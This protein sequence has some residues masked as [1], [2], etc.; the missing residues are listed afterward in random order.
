MERALVMPVLAAL[1]FAAACRGEAGTTEVDTRPSARFVNA[2]TGSGSGGFT[3][4]GQFAPGSALAP[5]QATQTCSNVD[6]GTTIFGFGPASS[7]GNALSGSPVVTSNDETI[8]AGGRYIVVAAGTAANP[9]LFVFGNGFS[10]ELT[11][12][13]AAVRFVSLVPA[14]GTGATNYVFYRGEIGAT[15]PLALNLPFGVQSG[16]S[17]VPSGAS[18]FSAMQVPGNVT[19]VPSSSA[20]LQGGSVNTIALVRDASGGFQLIHIPRCS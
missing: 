6:P 11:T 20:T 14:T 8:A 5:G 3:I 16:Y 4:N 1:L 18:T 13:Q 10:G 19:L 2:T 12:N 9:S 17:V 7:G 15:S